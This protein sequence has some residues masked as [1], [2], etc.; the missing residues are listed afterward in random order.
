MQKAEEN[1][2]IIEKVNGIPKGELSGISSRIGTQSKRNIT[3]RGTEAH[4]GIIFVYL[5]PSVKK[6]KGPEIM[7]GLKK[8]MEETF[9][10]LNKP[11]FELQRI[12][13]PLGRPFEIRVSSND[14][15]IRKSKAKEIKEN[16]K[17]KG[18][19]NI[20]DDQVFGKGV[21]SNS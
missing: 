16:W 15:K 4:L 19:L 7:D 10:K 20:N 21:K 17:V 9:K 11:L 13:P 2:K 8:S 5:S 12:G 3:E 1:L 6:K 18:V 14:D